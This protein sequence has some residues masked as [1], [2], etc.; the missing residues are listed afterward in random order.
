MIF[1]PYWS[2]IL[3]LVIVV[4][5]IT[6]IGVHLKCECFETSLYVELIKKFCSLLLWKSEKA[7]RAYLF[8]NEKEKLIEK[9][10]FEN[11]IGF[12]LEK[13]KT[14]S[15]VFTLQTIFYVLI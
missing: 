11:K 3:I 12:H 9:N 5:R 7:N 8:V 14:A 15:I 2:N 13:E 6:F 10:Y 4:L 1:N